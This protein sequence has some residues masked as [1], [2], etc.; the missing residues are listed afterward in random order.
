MLNKH[1]KVLENDFVLLESKC[2]LW[3]LK[4]GEGNLIQRVAFGFHDYK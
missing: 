2:K 4:C 3:F 1:N